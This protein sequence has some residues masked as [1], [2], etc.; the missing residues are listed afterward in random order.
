MTTPSTNFS[1]DKGS[2]ST[3]NVLLSQYLRY[4]YFFMVSVIL[5]LVIAY[6]YLRYTMP[7]YQINATLLIKD[8][9]KSASDEILKDDGASQ[10]PKSVE[11]EIQV[12]KS[13][14]LM[15]QVIDDLALT[16]G[17]F[18]PVRLGNE[19]DLY[20][21]SP[22]FV[23]ADSLNPIAYASPLFISIHNKQQYELQD[24]EG[25]TLGTYM[26]NQKVKS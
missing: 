25:N 20:G 11:N 9:P 14:S 7:V 24:S 3:I 18:K 17:Y 22:V 5:T 4:W 15:E 13:S 16:V 12:L 8:N 2:P 23:S 26:F 10:T 19:Q 21:S 6:W 1:G